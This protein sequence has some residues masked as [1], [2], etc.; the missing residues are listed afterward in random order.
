[1]KNVQRIKW[2]SNK[3][4][5]FTIIDDTDMANVKNIK[6]I[7]YYLYLKSIITT[8]TIWLYPSRN[9]YS[10]QTIHD[11]D[12][13]E[14]LYDIERKG[15]EIQLH[16]VGSGNFTR[17]EIIN[18]FELFR[19]TFGRYPSLHINHSLNPDNLYWGYKRYGILLKSFFR[20]LMPSKRRFY[21]DEVESKYFWGDISK[22]HIKYIR[23]R[24]FNGINTLRYDPHMPY[25]EEKKRF[26]NYWF[27]SS[28][29]H[30]AQEFNNLIKKKT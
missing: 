11:K 2:P 16:N 21:G 24:V 12:Y 9:S 14:F 5:A 10:G 22:H 13:L 1:M 17:F 30:T 18:G 27:S 29:G 15:F 20:I 8:K 19:K 4:F 25:I 23:N 3:E 7:Y 26:S 28:D 6:P